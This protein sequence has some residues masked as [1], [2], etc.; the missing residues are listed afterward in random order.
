MHSSTD[1]NHL[2]HCSKTVS[3]K[4][5]WFVGASMD[6]CHPPIHA[7]REGCVF[8]DGGYGHDGCSSFGGRVLP[9]WFPAR[10]VRVLRVGQ[11]GPALVPIAKA[12][13]LAPRFVHSSAHCRHW[14]PLKGQTE[15]ARQTCHLFCFLPSTSAV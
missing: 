6:C 4:R 3:T 10:S 12:W 7:A 9:K 11:V 5:L 2:V 14:S 13:C 15:R 1:D 8:R